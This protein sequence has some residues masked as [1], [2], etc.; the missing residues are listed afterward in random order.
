MPEI[1]ANFKQTYLRDPNAAAN[2][3]DQF[4]QAN[5]I[6]LNT[7]QYYFPELNQG[8]N[9]QD[10]YNKAMGGTSGQTASGA[11]FGG[12]S[13]GT[14]YIPPPVAQP[15]YVAPTPAPA[16]S[17]AV[18]GGTATRSAAPAQS[19]AV[20]GGTAT[21][22]ATPAPSG[23]VF[24]GTA[25]R[26]TPAPAPSGPVFGG[27][28]TQ[29]ANLGM[30]NTVNRAAVM[31][32]EVNVAKPYMVPGMQSS[33]GGAE[34]PKPTYTSI[35]PNLPTPQ[36]GMGF[37]QNLAPTEY[38]TG[39]RGMQQYNPAGTPD[40]VKTTG[41]RGMQPYKPGMGAQ[42]PNPYLNQ[43][44]S[45]MTG[46]VQ[47][48]F[49]QQT[50]P[51]LRSGAQA[52]G[53]YG[54][55]RQG[56]AEGVAAGNAATGLAGQLANLYGGAY[57]TDQANQTQRYGTNVGA[58]VSMRGQDQNYNLGAGQLGLGYQNSNNSYNLGVMN[59][60]T[61]QMGQA[62][63][64][65]LGLGQLGLGFQNAANTYNLGLGQLDLSNQGQ[66]Q[67]FYTS[68][69]GQ[70]L[71]QYQ[72]GNTLYN[73][74]TSGQMNVGRDQYN[75]GQQYQNAPLKAI[76]QYGRIISPYT[77]YNQTSTTSGESGG[78]M[79]GAAGGAMAGQQ[80]A[81]N[82]TRDTQRDNNMNIRNGDGFTNLPAYLQR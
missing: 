54:G 22:A 13:G 78:G 67:N 46:Q 75:V 36:Y 44:A 76:D 21:R 57:N 43:M 65:G 31:P 82:L 24:G 48:N 29:G 80:I 12:S 20:F 39:Q 45:G 35:D 25:T 17:G 62:Q 40:L 47:Q 52:A 30:G 41:E 66:N 61:T 38:T 34:T 74:G 55:S 5:E 53:Q 58:G 64:Y 19:G 70:D 73:D 63:Q 77:G 10:E 42:G 49:L 15:A 68:Q 56:I 81:N 9:A 27:S 50:M 14:P 60:Q 37:N 72:I 8:K 7:M 1:P 28:P 16:P 69:R 6:N 2:S 71:Q 32:D 3:A 18:F 79:S 59:N 23:A 11:S 26:T 51:Q 33:G 4:R